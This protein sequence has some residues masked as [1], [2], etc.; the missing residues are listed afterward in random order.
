MS[1]L[2]NIVKFHSFLA[3]ESYQQLA[4]FEFTIWAGM[5]KTLNIYYNEENYT[6]VEF[7][8]KYHH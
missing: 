6:K 2:F 5:Y 7:F 1:K 4:N 3:A 8:R